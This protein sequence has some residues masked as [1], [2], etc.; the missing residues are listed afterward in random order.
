MALAELRCFAIEMFSR[1]HVELVPNMDIVSILAIVKRPAIK[2]R[3][4][5][6]GGCLPIRLTPLAAQ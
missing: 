2:G 6:L 1:Y 5:E 3:E 4:A